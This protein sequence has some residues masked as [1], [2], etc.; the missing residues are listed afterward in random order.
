MNAQPTPLHAERGVTDWPRVTMPVLTVA[1]QALE[2]RVLLWLVVA[3][4]GWIWA[5]TI[6]HPELFRIG[7]ATLYSLT[8]LW[9]FVWRM[10]RRE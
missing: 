9:P 6:L 10:R 2:E 7:A 3:G 8:V 1:L 4:A 5:Y